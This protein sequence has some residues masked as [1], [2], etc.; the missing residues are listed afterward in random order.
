MNS[1]FYVPFGRL[2]ATAD[3]D[4]VAKAKREALREKLLHGGR[5]AISP[6]GNATDNT[7]PNKATINIPA[8]KL[9][10]SSADDDTVAKAKR[11]ALREK[12][13]HGDRIGISPTGSVTDNK[14]N[15][16]NIQIPAGKLAAIQWYQSN[17]DLLE[18]EKMVMRQKFPDFTLEEVGDGRLAWVGKLNLGIYESKTHVPMEY[19]IMAIYMS[20]HPHQQMGSSVR[21]YPLL[22]SVDELIEKCGFRPYHLLRDAN[23]DLYLCTNEAGDQKTGTEVTTAASVIA[24]ACKW[25]MAYELV[26]TGDLDKDIF[27]RHGGI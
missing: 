10:D 12:L 22:P 13:L 24:W 9:A 17:P 18:A 1:L 15:N 3:D 19:N 16:S 21:I 23:E 4:A 25:F 11:A 27:N 7:D 6:E 8:G 2:A 14:N 26:L 5:I 20:N